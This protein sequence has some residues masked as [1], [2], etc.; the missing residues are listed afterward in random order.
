MRYRYLHS[1]EPLTTN[2]GVTPQSYLGDSSVESSTPTPA[3]F[4]AHAQAPLPTQ[5]DRGNLERYRCSGISQGT[6]AGTD[7]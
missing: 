4:F 1:K 7:S 6:Y 5:S 2:I 3:S